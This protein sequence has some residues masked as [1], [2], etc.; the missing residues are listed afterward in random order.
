MNRSL[1]LVLG[2]CALMLS[3]CSKPAP[4]AYVESLDVPDAVFFRDLGL[5][6]CHFRVRAIKNHTVTIW[7]ETYFDGVLAEALCWGTRRT[8]GEDERVDEE[9]RFT[10]RRPDQ[11]APGDPPQVT[12]QFGFDS[13]SARRDWM[14]DP[15]DGFSLTSY[16]SVGERSELVAGKATTV[17]RLVA[18][19]GEALIGGT[20]EEVKQHPVAVLI[21]CRMDPVEPGEGRSGFKAFAGLPRD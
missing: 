18:T 1:G 7:I 21:R 16:G 3:S 15:L 8:P 13:G 2:L 6:A 12:W 20:D 19:D 14:E 10:R 4:P 9:F 5:E 17:W 11:A